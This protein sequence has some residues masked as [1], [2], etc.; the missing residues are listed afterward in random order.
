MVTGL[1]IPEGAEFSACL[2]LDSTLFLNLSP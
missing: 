1:L 2:V